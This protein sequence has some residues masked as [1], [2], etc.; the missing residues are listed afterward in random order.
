MPPDRPEIFNI[1]QTLE[2]MA[3][4]AP[5]RRAIVFPVGHDPKGRS[6][7]IQLSFQQLNEECDRYAH[8][9][10]QSGIYQGEHV[11]LMVT[12]GLELIAV[13]FALVKLGAVPIFI[14]PGM[15][16]KAF[17]QCVNDTKPTAFIGIPIAHLLRCIYPQ[18][19]KTIQ[20]IITVGKRWFWGGVTLDH[21]RASQFKPFPAA[22]TT[23]E[24]EAAITFT[25]GST[26]IP[27]G[28]VYL[29]GMFGALIELMRDDIGVSEG[30]V[31][32]PGL[33]IFAL[34]NP[35]LGVTTIIPEMDP[36]KPAKVNPVNIV[37]A[38]QTHG[39]TSSF[40]SPAIWKRVGRYCIENNIQLT[41]I[42]RILMA[43]APV[44]PSLIEQ[45]SHIL[46]NGDVYTPFGATEALPITTMS[47]REILADT[48]QLS[49]QGR[50]VCIGR[51]TQG[52]KIH[53][54]QITDYPI[55][56]WD[57]ALLV[58]QGQVGEIVVKGP[59]VTRIYINRPEQ[60][61]LAK[62]Q[63]RDGI[64]HRMGDL[65]YYDE[66]GRL[67]FCGRK[68]HRV[69]TSHG[70]MLPVQ[71]EAI[72]NLHPYVARSAL[73][74]IGKRGE[75]TPV[76]VVEPKTNKNSATSQA[77]KKF[78]TELLAL[79]DKYEHTR[80]IH[81]ILFHPSLPVDI[82]HNAKIQREKLALWAENRLKSK[83]LG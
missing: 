18:H 69:E 5:F 37:D 43:G 68:S 34:L 36:T 11:L 35:A 53:I 40:G 59:V 13:S 44:P 41:S 3:I 62:I 32:L 81:K 77:R 48:A 29:H 22:P 50:G 7:F 83:H 16:R 78:I 72:F 57:D 27:K 31:D 67:W 51:A 39:V 71:C 54:I 82:R 33:Y 24:S 42:K 46:S 38:I 6:K 23:R 10:A 74:G 9:L 60:T 25:S 26:G 28:V 21:V 58:P 64:W 17:I 20:H 4:R 49:A 76:L 47:G 80:I 30:E 19:F 56:S 75:Q 79:G 12:P 14:D 2:Y 63:D 55:S 65:G 70:L 15:G 52:N 61:A 45:F 1:A 73:V 66:L 8:G